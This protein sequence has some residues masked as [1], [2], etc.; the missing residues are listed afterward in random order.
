MEIEDNPSQVKD[1]VLDGG[2][3]QVKGIEVVE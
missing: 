2:V 3:D 1:Q